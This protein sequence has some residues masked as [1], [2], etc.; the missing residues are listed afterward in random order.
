MVDVTVVRFL[1]FQIMFEA[2]GAYADEPWQ[3]RLD[4]IRIESCSGIASG[5]VAGFTGGSSTTDSS[6]PM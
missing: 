1:M 2:T 5:G 4:A 6:I 3:V